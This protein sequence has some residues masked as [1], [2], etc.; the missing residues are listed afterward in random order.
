ML[1]REFVDHDQEFCQPYVSAIFCSGSPGQGKETTKTTMLAPES[2]FSRP[3][4][5]AIVPDCLVH[6]HELRCLK[7]REPDRRR[8][9]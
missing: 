6:T 2:S 1:D 5:N 3:D 4:R 7:V 8:V 9:S